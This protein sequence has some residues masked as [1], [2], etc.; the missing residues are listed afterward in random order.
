[1]S[2]KPHNKQAEQVMEAVIHSYTN[3]NFSTQD[4]L[5][6]QLSF[7]MKGKILGHITYSFPMSDLV[8]ESG[9]YKALYV[10]RGKPGNGAGYI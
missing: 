10:A 1:M 9:N 7:D 5:Q 3:L 2:D 8:G 6:T 4:L